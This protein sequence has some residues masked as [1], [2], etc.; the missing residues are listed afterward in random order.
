MSTS[1]AAEIRRIKAELQKG[2]AMPNTFELIYQ[3]VRRKGSWLCAARKPR[4]GKHPLLP[5]C[6]AKRADFPCIC[7][8]RR[9]YPA[10]HAGS[11]WRGVPAQWLCGYGTF[12][13]G[14]NWQLNPQK[15][16]SPLE[17]FFARAN[18]KMIFPD[19]QINAGEY[20]I[21]AGDHDLV[22]FPQYGKGLFV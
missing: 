4:S 7:V 11:G 1:A 20:A 17:V 22:A 13:L 8:W 2:E 19:A 14:T 21:V 10:R 6:D 15:G 16:F 9:G 18:F 12:P 5:G 3:V